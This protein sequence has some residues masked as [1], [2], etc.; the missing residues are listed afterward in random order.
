MLSQKLLFDSL[1][2]C[3]FLETPQRCAETII[4]HDHDGRIQRLEVQDEHRIHVEFRH[5]LQGQR[6]AFGRSLLS[7]LVD[8]RGHCDKVGWFG[9]TEHHGFHPVLQRKGEWKSRVEIQ[10]T[11]QSTD[12]RTSG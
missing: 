8:A 4:V 7:A 10:D 9:Q 1:R 11:D 2:F 5:R 12:L 3:D 6:N